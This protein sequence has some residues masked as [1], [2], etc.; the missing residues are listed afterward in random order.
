MKHHQSQ[1]DW[2]KAFYESA[3]GWWGESWYSG[4]NL[5]ERLELIRK[6]ANP[7]DKRIL[8]LGAGTGETASYLCD[9]GYS[10][11]AVDIC[12]RNIE[13]MLQAAT[14]RPSLKVVEGDFLKVTI[15]EKFPTIY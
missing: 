4:E 1:V 3:V 5:K 7:D 6:Y 12:K 11:T 8:E 13:L 15:E 10:V 9:H 14:A 2:I